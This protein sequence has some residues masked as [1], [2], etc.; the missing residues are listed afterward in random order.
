MVRVENGEETQGCYLWSFEGFEGS[1]YLR[2]NWRKSNETSPNGRGGCLKGGYLRAEEGFH[3][4]KKAEI[5]ES[6]PQ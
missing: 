3:K 6:Y 4:K 1:V 2:Q 5:G